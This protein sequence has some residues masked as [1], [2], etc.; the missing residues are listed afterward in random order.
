MN[1]TKL[2]SLLGIA[3]A[4]ILVFSGWFLTKSLLHRQEL[5]LLSQTGTLPVQTA[6]QLP[7][8]SE[9][10]TPPRDLT[11]SE[12]YQIL[13]SWELGGEETLHEPMDGQLTMEQAMNAARQLLTHLTGLGLLPEAFATDSQATAYLCRLN[14]DVSRLIP[15]SPHAVPEDIRPESELE[16]YYSYWTVTFTQGRIQAVLTVNGVTGQVWRA[17]IRQIPLEPTSPQ[18][19]DTAMAQDYMDFLGLEANSLFKADVC[20]TR[21]PGGDTRTQLQLEMS[22]STLP[23]EES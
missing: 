9:T 22:L 14:A 7:E 10:P 19:S 16:P 8:E 20:Q 21:S 17:N 4:L 23:M 2:L 18:L 12:I 13:I 15:M 11:D 3:A 1:K 5:R 6:A